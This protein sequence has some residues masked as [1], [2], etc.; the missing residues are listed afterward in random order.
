MPQDFEQTWYNY[1]FSIN[2]AAQNQVACL[3]FTFL[4]SPKSGDYRLMSSLIFDITCH[5]ITLG[6][7]LDFAT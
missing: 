1:L 3:V 4:I 6:F 7:F 2:L 5:F